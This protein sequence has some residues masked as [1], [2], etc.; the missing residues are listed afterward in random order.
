VSEKHPNPFGVYDMHGNVW[1]WCLE[2]WHPSIY[3]QRA[4]QTT[5]DPLG[6]M[7]GDLRIVRGG[8]W[9][10]DAFNCRSAQRLAM[11]HPASVVGL[12][13]A[14]SV[15]AVREIERARKKKG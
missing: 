9:D 8:C 6:P 1:E 13:L 12:R 5:K 10:N 15:A 7:I 3:Q 14:I 4:S 2:A 11:D